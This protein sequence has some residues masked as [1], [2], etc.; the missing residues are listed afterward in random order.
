[1]DLTDVTHSDSLPA[2]PTAAKQVPSDSAPGTITGSATLTEVNSDS[3]S[4]SI[5][6]ENVESPTQLQQL[7]TQESEYHSCQGSAPNSHRN[8][9][10]VPP[11]S[12]TSPQYTQQPLRHSTTSVPSSSTPALNSSGVASPAPSRPETPWGSSDILSAATTASTPLIGTPT[13][14]LHMAFHTKLGWMTWKDRESS[15]FALFERVFG[16]TRAELKFGEAMDTIGVDVEVPTAQVAS[17]EKE[18]RKK[19]LLAEIDKIHGVSP[20][21]RAPDARL[22]RTSKS[23]GSGV[24]EGNTKSSILSL[25]DRIKALHKCHE[26]RRKEVDAILAQWDSMKTV[27]NDKAVKMDAKIEAKPPRMVE[28]ESWV[29]DRLMQELKTVQEW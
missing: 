25:Q 18:L 2:L 14:T 11:Q 19:Y 6:V 28:I 23:L 21:V 13:T 5:S 27:L 29:V 22:L 1:M 17:L 26:S 20:S 7:A 3:Q 8:S 10:T 4:I 16:C 24:L 9:L 12:F 15:L